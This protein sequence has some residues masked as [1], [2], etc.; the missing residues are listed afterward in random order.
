MPPLDPEELLEQS[1]QADLRRAISSAYYGLFHFLLTAAADML[2]GPDKRDTPYYGLVYRSIDHGQLRALSSRLSKS[3][4]YD[5]YY[6]C[7]A[8]EPIEAI[9]EAQQAIDLFKR[10][11]TDQQRAFLK[12]L[13]FRP[14]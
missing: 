11:T 7:E 13:L 8:D 10:G 9:S 1:T 3:A 6:T 2:V 5:P 4:D 14:R 12:L